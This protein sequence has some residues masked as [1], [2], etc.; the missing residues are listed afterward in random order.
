MVLLAL[1]ERVLITPGLIGTTE[2][3]EISSSEDD[4]SCLARLLGRFGLLD[5][6]AGVGGIS[7]EPFR[8]TLR[9]SSNL[10]RA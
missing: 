1:C 7:V 5:R 6:G 2:V 10:P 9:S 8:S 4:S 3:G